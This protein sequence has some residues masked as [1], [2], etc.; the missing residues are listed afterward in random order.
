MAKLQ[1]S[2]KLETILASVVSEIIPRDKTQHIKTAKIYWE[3]ITWANTEEARAVLEIEDK[4]H[5]IEVLM[6]ATSKE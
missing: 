6:V 5:M 4:D 1:H 3:Q 2:L